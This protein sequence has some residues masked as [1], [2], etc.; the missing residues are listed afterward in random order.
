MKKQNKLFL[1]LLVGSAFTCSFS[2]AATEIFVEPVIEK[3]NVDTKEG[4]SSVLNAMATELTGQT[5]QA[6]TT[7]SDLVKSNQ[8]PI[9]PI[10]LA[11]VFIGCDFIACSKVYKIMIDQEK[12]NGDVG[13][14]EL[15]FS[16]AKTQNKM[17]TLREIS[18][19]LKTLY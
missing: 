14:L 8:E 5:K 4:L 19:H 17:K 10:K 15:L 9:A 12:L 13:R 1:T 2:K 7:L 11:T 16:N 6:F 3:F 18:N